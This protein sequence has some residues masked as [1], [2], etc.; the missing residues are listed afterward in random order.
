[1]LVTIQNQ[2]YLSKSLDTYTKVMY[3]AFII[4]ESRHVSLRSCPKQQLRA[5]FCS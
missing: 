4:S 1:M 2:E 5:G 3:T